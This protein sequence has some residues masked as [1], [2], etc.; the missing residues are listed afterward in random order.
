MGL[1]RWMVQHKRWTLPTL[2]VLSVFL[3]LLCGLGLM[4]DSGWAPAVA[5]MLGVAVWA[6]TRS[7]R[8]AALAALVTCAVLIILTAVVDGAVSTL[9]TA[10][11]IVTSPVGL[12]VI[13]L[14][15]LALF[16]GGGKGAGKTGIS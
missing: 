1:A 12:G 10:W 3:L 9:A 2:R 13:V 16:M 8:V 15:V 4:R 11:L 7:K 5:G 6:F 14:V